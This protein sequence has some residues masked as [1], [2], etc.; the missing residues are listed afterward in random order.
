MEVIFKMKVICFFHFFFFYNQFAMA[1]HSNR[2]LLSDKRTKTI[3]LYSKLQIIPVSILDEKVIR[4]C[5]G[6][7]LR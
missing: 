2:L 3:S 1:W 5:P 7:F 6:D 4:A